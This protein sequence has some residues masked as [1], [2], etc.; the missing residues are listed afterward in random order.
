MNAHVGDELVI[1]SQQVGR[2]DQHGEIIEV[3][4]AGGQHYRVRWSDGRETILFPGPDATVR[5]AAQADAQPAEME[6]RTAVIELRVEEDGEACEARATLHTST[7]V[8]TGVGTARRN[9]S[10]PPMPLIGEEFAIARSLADLAGQLE[11]AARA[12]TSSEASTPRHL[13]P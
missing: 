8:F 4:T 6:T 11:S 5:R 9:P 1:R 7:G 10:D 13:V 3:I 12:A 2:S